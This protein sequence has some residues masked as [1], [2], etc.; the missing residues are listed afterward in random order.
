MKSNHLIRD[1]TSSAQKAGAAK[2][3]LS[4]AILVTAALLAGDAY[5]HMVN[6]IESNG[7]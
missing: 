6:L 7:E 1:H 4:E 5:A 3:E 2:E